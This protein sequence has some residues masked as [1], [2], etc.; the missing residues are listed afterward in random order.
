MILPIATLLLGVYLAP[1]I[2]KLKKDNENKRLFRSIQIELNDNLSS[3]VGDIND[4]YRSVCNRMLNSDDFIHLSLPLK[5]EFT[6]LNKNLSD[7]YAILT[8]D[9]RRGMRVLLAQEKIIEDKQNSIIEKFKK[10]NNECLAAEQSLLHS[11]LCVYYIL[12]GLVNQCERY[13]HGNEPTAEVVKKTAKS[14][15]LIYP[16]T[17]F[18]AGNYL[19]EYNQLTA[20]IETE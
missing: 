8:R 4:I 1:M 16:I 13:K 15:E 6:L 20:P 18:S 3:I 12:N 9:Q 17:L 5:M 10:S 14:L 19:Y 2:E 11:Y 7:V